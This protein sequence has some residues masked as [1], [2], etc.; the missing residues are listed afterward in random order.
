MYAALT[1]R[2]R[3]ELDALLVVAPGARVS[4]LELELELERGRVGPARRSTAGCSTVDQPIAWSSRS[5]VPTA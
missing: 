5:A 4:E 3:L 2:Q 1:E